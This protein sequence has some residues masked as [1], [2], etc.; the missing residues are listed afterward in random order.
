MII[1]GVRTVDYPA[2]VDSFCTPLGAVFD[3]D[4][5]ILKSESVYSFVSVS[6]SGADERSGA[7]PMRLSQGIE[8]E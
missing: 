2:T 3:F 6:S 4:Y 1:K 5:G 8:G 7:P